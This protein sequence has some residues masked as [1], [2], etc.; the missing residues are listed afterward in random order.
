MNKT[1]DQYSGMSW[2]IFVTP[3]SKIPLI[4]GKI[5]FYF[6]ALGNIVKYV[7]CDN[8][9]EHQQAFRDICSNHGVTMAYT[10]QKT[11]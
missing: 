3:K 1:R 2:N 4:L 8:A 6:K 10:A 7:R 11:P 5:L 9:G